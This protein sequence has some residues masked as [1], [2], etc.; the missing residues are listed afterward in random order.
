MQGRTTIV[1]AHR[2][3]TVIDADVIHVMENGKVVQ[4]GRHADLLAEGGLYAHLH[5]LQFSEAAA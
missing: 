1:I 4:S 5:A 3:S 2:L